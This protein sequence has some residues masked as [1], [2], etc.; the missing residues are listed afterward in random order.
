MFERYFG[1]LT[2]GARQALVLAEKEARSLS[3]DYVRTDDILLGLIRE[4]QGVAAKALASL[5]VTIDAGRQEA[6]GIVGD[7]ELGPSRDIPGCTHR[8]QKVL[9]L[10]MREALKLGHG[11][12]GTEDLLLGLIHEGAG[13]AARVLEGLGV[14]LPAARERVVDLLRSAPP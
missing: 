13:A 9:E 2:G 10:S 7:V 1:R 5:G 3:H 12:I 6:R 11:S 8:A 4:G 14:G